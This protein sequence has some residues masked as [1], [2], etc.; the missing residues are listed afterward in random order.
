[1]ALLSFAVAGIVGIITLIVGI[2]MY[3]LTS[4][5]HMKALRMLGY[6]TP[7][8]A[9]IPILRCM[10]YADS[11]SKEDNITI[12][13]QKI[14][15][16]IFKFWWVLLVVAS[17]LTYVNGT[18]SSVLTIVVNVICLGTIY[19]KMYARLE[20]KEESET[21]VI[22]YLSGWLTIIAIVKFFIYP[23][24]KSSN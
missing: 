12:F 13:G 2:I 18:L 20:N 16:N 22:G 24:N 8:H 23:E 21:Q 7:W 11:V 17:L 19:G 3:V 4:I 6:H 1:M 10:A 14:P 15:A 5:S 9:W